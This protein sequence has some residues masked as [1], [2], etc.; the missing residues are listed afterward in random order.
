MLFYA[1]SLALKFI[2]KSINKSLANKSLKEF[3]MLHVYN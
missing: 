1:L 2:I 3:F